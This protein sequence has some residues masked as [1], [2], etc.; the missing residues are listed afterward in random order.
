M[1]GFA[2]WCELDVES[3]LWFSGR[4]PSELKYSWSKYSRH[5]ESGP[6]ELATAMDFPQPGGGRALLN[7]FEN[8]PRLMGSMAR[9]ALMLVGI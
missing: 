5:V 9:T 4:V 6:P 7:I 1:R 2:F 8:S 3:F